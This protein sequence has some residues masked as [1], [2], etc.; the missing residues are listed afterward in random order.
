LVEV[1]TIRNIADS[2]PKEDLEIS[3]IIHKV[4]L[5]LGIDEEMIHLVEALDVKL[6]NYPRVYFESI[7][8]NLVSNAVKYAN[9][10]KKLEL[11][12]SSFIDDNGRINL[13]FKDNGLGIDLD[14]YKDKVFGFKKTFHKHPEANGTGLF[15]TKNHIE[16]LG[17]EIS[18]ESSLN[19]GTCFKI[20]L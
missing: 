18:V 3:P 20:I 10:E 8:H 6:V 17:G 15:F 13:H 19:Q 11:T 5:G 1:V 12:I 14:K 9:P 4:M 16:T 7:I 2:L